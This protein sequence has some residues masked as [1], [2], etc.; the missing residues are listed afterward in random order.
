M[1]A[2]WHAG[3]QA[4]DDELP[5]DREGLRDAQRC[6]LALLLAHEDNEDMVLSRPRLPP[7]VRLRAQP[8]ER[9][10]A[11][12][13]DLGAL[14]EAPG[15]KS[16]TAPT[17]GHRSVPHLRVPKQCVLVPLALAMHASTP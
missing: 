1:T 5:I 15:W 9:V 2:H 7:S 6:L 10:A 8:G 14:A 4:R 13:F 16:P 17:L 12:C 3:L 11:E